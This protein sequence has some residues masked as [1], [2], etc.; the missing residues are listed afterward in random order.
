MS[1]HDICFMVKYLYCIRP[2]CCTYPYKRIF[3]QFHGLQI[4][5]S[6]LCVY[7]FI[8]AYV[9]G[10]HLLCIDLLMQFKWVPT[11]Y[12]FKNKI[13]KKSDKHHQTG[14]LLIFFSSPEPKAQD[15]LLWSLAVRHPSVHSSIHPPGPVFF[16]LHVE[17]WSGIESLFKLSLSVNQDSRHALCGK[18]T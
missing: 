1:T 12:A 5:A 18:N 16:K 2:D 13:R 9:V 11:I 17:P 15:E 4:T 6:V 3:K 10:I 14:L 8:Q 7:F